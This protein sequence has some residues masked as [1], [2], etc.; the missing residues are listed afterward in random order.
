MTGLNLL[1]RESVH[2]ATV[3]GRDQLIGVRRVDREVQDRRGRQAVTDA[4][5]RAAA[6]TGRHE[7]AD[8]GR[9]LDDRMAQVRIDQRNIGAQAGEHDDA[10]RAEH[11]DRAAAIDVDA[12]DGEADR[13][14]CEQAD[15]GRGHQHQQGERTE[16]GKDQEDGHGGFSGLI[17]TS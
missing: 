1:K 2:A 11:F 13:S 10:A 8:I 6:G 14:R 9:Q 7:D 4:L 5:V 15:L 16:G 3:G 17:F 12:D